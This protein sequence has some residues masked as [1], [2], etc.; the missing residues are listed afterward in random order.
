MAAG[1]MAKGLIAALAVLGGA[2]AA[3]AQAMTPM[4]GEVTSFS[5]EFAVRVRPYNPYQHRIQ[6]E[7]RVYDQDFRPVA[8]KVSPRRLM[9]GGKASRPVLVVVG[10]EGAAQR[11]VRVC[12]ESVP[13]PRQKTRIKAQICGRFIAR[14]LR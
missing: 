1:S 10:F 2:S 14:R 12:T 4:R 11:R 3:D 13:F 9:L 8:A 7:V 6:V 5:D